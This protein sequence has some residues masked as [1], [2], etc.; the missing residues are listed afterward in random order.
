[1]PGVEVAG[2]R[3]SS[4]WIS[5]AWSSSAGEAELEQDEGTE[6]QENWYSFAAL[7]EVIVFSSENS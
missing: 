3:S 2:L 4:W 5:G 7:A 6:V 1:M